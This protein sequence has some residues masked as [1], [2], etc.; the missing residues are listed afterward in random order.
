[1]TTYTLP[2]L[3]R[4]WAASTLTFAQELPSCQAF[5]EQLPKTASGVAAAIS[6]RRALAPNCAYL[7]LVK[8]LNHA[9]ATYVLLQ[10]GLVVDA[11]LSVRNALETVL[12]LELLS[13][14]PDLCEQ[15][16]QG[17]ELRPAEV[18][19]H[20]AAASTVQVGDLVIERPNEYADARFAYAWLSR[21]THANLESLN[22][23]A[24]RVDEN[25]FV[26]HVG[27]ARLPS[28]AVAISKI[29]GVAFL[30]ALV[31]TAA[32]HSPQL[33]KS[34]RARFAKLKRAVEGIRE[35]APNPVLRQR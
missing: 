3:E 22:H 21:I 32:V 6:G 28:Q 15:W 18:R 34:D 2:D 27:G 4:H 9:F 23:A 7:L 20:L 17:K 26:L 11:A 16:S 13:L 10:R 29:L 14:R 1:M 8:S 12:L 35:A 30:R 5:F 24:T 19:Q 33:L 25:G 31:T